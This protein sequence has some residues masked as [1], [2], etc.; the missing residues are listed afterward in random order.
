MRF[1]KRH[2]HTSAGL[3]TGRPTARRSKTDWRATR[4]VGVCSAV[5][6]SGVDVYS[7]SAVDVYSAIETVLKG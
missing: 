4:G 5:E 7:A 3:H 6:T 2:G 1:V